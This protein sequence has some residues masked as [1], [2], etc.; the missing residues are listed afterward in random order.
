MPTQSAPQVSQ[1]QPISYAAP[2]ATD[3]GSGSGGFNHFPMGGALPSSGGPSPANAG[4]D[5]GD[6]GYPSVPTASYPQ[7]PQAAPT[8]GESLQGGVQR[9]VGLL[10]S[11]VQFPF[12]GQQSTASLSDRTSQLR[13]PTGS[14]VQQPG[15]ADLYAWDQQ[16]PGLLQRL[17]PNFSGNQPGPTPRKR[18]K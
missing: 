1:T 4:P 18:R 14:P 12:Q 9:V 10:S 3:G 11:P 5:G 2:V 7:A 8:S 16:Q 6:Q 17:F 13:F 15:D